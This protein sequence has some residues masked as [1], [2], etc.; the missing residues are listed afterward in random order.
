MKRGASW[1][2]KTVRRSPYRSIAVAFVFAWICWGGAW[3][4]RDMDYV[5]VILLS[6]GCAA[7]VFMIG[8][9]IYVLVSKVERNG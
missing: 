2:I 1:L 3:A 4:L 6:L 5:P 8:A 9:S 7:I